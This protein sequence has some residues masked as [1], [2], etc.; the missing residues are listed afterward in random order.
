MNAEQRIEVRARQYPRLPDVSSQYGAPMGRRE[1]RPTGGVEPGPN[2]EAPSP[3]D[4]QADRWLQRYGV[5]FHADHTQTKAAPWAPKGARAGDS[6]IGQHWTVTLRVPGVRPFAMDLD[7]GRPSP[8]KRGPQCAPCVDRVWASARE[9]A[10]V[11]RFWRAP[12]LQPSEQH[13]IRQIMLTE[14][15]HTARLA[16]MTKLA[17]DI[18]MDPDAPGQPTT[19]EV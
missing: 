8:F 5:T 2:G 7:A 4:I 6:G 10:G 18:Y 19:Q 13:A 9:R 12:D 15:G 16:A 3:Y 14:R 11:H 17:R 1:S